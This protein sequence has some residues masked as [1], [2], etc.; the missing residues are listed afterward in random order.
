MADIA[1][2]AAY[3]S[4]VEDPEEGFL[5]I[6]FAQGEHEDETYVLFRQSLGGGPIWFE[7]GDEA[8]GAE[9]ALSSVRLTAKGLEIALRPAMS[10]KFGFATSVQ[11]G[12]GKC[13]DKVET[14]AALE[15][16]LGEVW[17]A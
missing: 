11:V 3:A 8:F 2:K 12:L 6:G 4:V 5:F 17:Q 14:L 10:A 1:F 15:T 9:D 7:L 13:E 16:M